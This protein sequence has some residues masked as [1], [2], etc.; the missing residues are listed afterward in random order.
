MAKE[1]KIIR[2]FY[3]RIQGYIITDTRTGNKEARDFYQRIL[4]YYI[5]DLDQTRNFYQK[6]ISRG[7]TLA[8]LIIE[9]DEARKNK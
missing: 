4:G 3:N 2:D 9:A 8:S 7:D 1:T 5:K 6:V